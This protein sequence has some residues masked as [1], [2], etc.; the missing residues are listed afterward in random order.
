MLHTGSRTP[1]FCS[2]AA[3]EHANKL[4]KQQSGEKGSFS[5]EVM[6]PGEER[7]SWHGERAALACG[8]TVQSRWRRQVP[9]G[10]QPEVAGGP[11]GLGDSGGGGASRAE[12]CSLDDLL[13]SRQCLLQK[14]CPSLSRAVFGMRFRISHSLNWGENRTLKC[15]SNCQIKHDNGDPSGGAVLFG[16]RIIKVLF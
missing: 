12:V 15:L 4:S 7:P 10:S 14:T 5:E 16:E 6:G 3:T 2:Q 13:L 9:A 11:G 1:Q 8:H